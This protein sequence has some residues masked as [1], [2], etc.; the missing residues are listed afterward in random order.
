MAKKKKAK[1]YT[2]VKKAEI[3]NFIESKGRGGQAAALKKFKVTAATISSWRK[4]KLKT[5]VSSSK[6]STE[7]TAVKELIKIT[8]EIDATKV[9]LEDLKKRHKILK[10]K[11]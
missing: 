10:A 3:L 5:K 6:I 7:L 2:E 11:V 9:K 8:T 4:Q 1:R